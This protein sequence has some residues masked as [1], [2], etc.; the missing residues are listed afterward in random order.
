MSTK[1]ASVHAAN[2]L[3][4]F[5]KCTDSSEKPGDSTEELR[6][7]PLRHRVSVKCKKATFLRWEAGQES[8]EKPLRGIQLLLKGLR[9]LPTEGG[10][11]GQS[12]LAKKDLPRL[13][14]LGHKTGN[15]AFHSTFW[16]DG[17]VLYLVLCGG[18][19]R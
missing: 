4:V 1:P 16:E 7:T 14:K 3:M 5:V 6:E 12:S 9:H 10:G 2:F 19:M 11:G 8:R 18:Y 15:R 17:N 13:K